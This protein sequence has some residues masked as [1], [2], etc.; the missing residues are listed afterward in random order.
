MNASIV[1]ACESDLARQID[2]R[3]GT[4]AEQLAV[5]RP[6]LRV[7]DSV[8]DAAELSTVRVDA[9]ALITVRQ[10]KYSVPASLAGLRVTAQIGA[11]QIRVFPPREGGCAP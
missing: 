11:A 10:N 4:V 1:D 8:F 6:L 9:K 3:P 5:E 7:I 2:G